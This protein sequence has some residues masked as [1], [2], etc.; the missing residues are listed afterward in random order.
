MWGLA[1]VTEIET[2]VVT[3]ALTVSVVLPEILPE[4][5]VIVVEPVVRE[6]ARP[7]EPDTSLIVATAGT[8]EA[9]VTEEVKSCVLLSE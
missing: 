8:D 7:L 1:G 3:N 4:V 6:A 5:A 2:R 9:Q